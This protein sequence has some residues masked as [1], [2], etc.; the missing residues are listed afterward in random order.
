METYNKYIGQIFD[1][2]YRIEKVIGLGGMAVVFKA[3]DMSCGITVAVKMLREDMALD[4]TNVKR[5]ENES[6]AVVLLE[7]ENIVKIYDV[8]VDGERKYFVMEFLEGITLKEYMKKRGRLDKLEVISCAEQILRALEHAHAKGVIHRDIK[9][10]N[11][12]V[13]PNGQIKVTDFGIAKLPSA[14][15]VTMEDKAIG[16]VYYISPEQASGKKVDIRTD[17]YSLGALLYEMATGVLPYDGDNSV[18]IAL[19][20]IKED[21]TPPREIDKSIPEGLEQL[22]TKAMKRSPAERFQTA[23]EMLGCVLRLKKNPGGS[24]RLKKQ[25][26][27]K[28]KKKKEHGGT[29]MFPIILGAVCAFAIALIIAILYMINVLLVN[30]S[31]ADD[32]FRVG[33]YVEKYYNNELEEELNKYF[34]KVNVEYEYSDVLDSGFI[35]EQSVKANVIRKIKTSEITLTIS[36]GREQMKMPDLRY[37]SLSD[38]IVEISN[39]NF[40]LKITQVK[41]PDD[42]IEEGYL[43]STDPA[44]GT[45]INKGETITLIVSDGEQIT[46]VTVPNLVY[47]SQKK[48]RTEQEAYKLLSDANLKI[49][50]VTRI[51]SIDYD[52]GVVL[53]QSIPAGQKVAGGV[54]TVDL[55][56]SGGLDGEVTGDE[57]YMV[58]VSSTALEVALAKLSSY[59]MD[60]VIKTSYL[61]D[62]SFP[63]GVVC[64][65]DPEPR[66]KVQRGQEITLYVSAGAA[67]LVAVPDLSNMSQAE[68]IAALTAANLKVGSIAN[69]YSST[70]SV[71]RVCYQN[72]APYTEVAEGTVINF[73]L[74]N[75]PNPHSPQE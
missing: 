26:T 60:F 66:M 40:E 39:L 4:P 55:V 61:N 18:S 46:Y 56:I 62:T 59:T 73:N 44:P 7:H 11:I 53:E 9:P 21:P 29:S 75:G 2:R 33:N 71:G 1:G 20:H 48:N 52:E 38:A 14:E 63:A 30:P 64:Y 24:L 57:M 70:I 3:T 54:T 74:S 67:T 13:K 25:S 43:I 49:G 50:K 28:V 65:T 34:T 72:V 12:M 68:A 47:D 45:I 8:N 32:D 23:S 17:I 58:D 15:T 37:Y 36:I 51:Q 19:M 31:K 69:Q 10:Q 22:I 16:T 42:A 5:F 6:K 41:R 35:L 27:G